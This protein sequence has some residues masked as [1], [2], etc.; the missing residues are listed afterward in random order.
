[1]LDKIKKVLDIVKGILLYILTPV[2]IL[3]GYVYYL[4]TKANA[5]RDQLAHSKAEA[6]LAKILTKKA[7]K[8]NEANKD[9]DYYRTLRDTYIKQFEGSVPNRHV[10]LTDSKSLAERFVDLVKKGG[11]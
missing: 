4:T 8:E 7:D 9:E 3:L 5:L 11:L 2:G 10:P 6:E 1:M